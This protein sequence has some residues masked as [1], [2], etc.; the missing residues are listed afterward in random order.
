MT[1]RWIV[2]AEGDT[3]GV[4]DDLDTAE[5]H[6]RATWAERHQMTVEEIPEWLG[7]DLKFGDWFLYDKRKHYRMREWGALKHD[8]LT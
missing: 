3:L 2:I 8:H 4:A 6:L 1:D 7:L 5:R